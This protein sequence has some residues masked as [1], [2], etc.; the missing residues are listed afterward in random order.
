M[1]NA[2]GGSL[3]IGVLPGDADLLFDALL[4]EFHRVYPKISL[5]VIE[6]TKIMEQVIH[7]A[8]DIGV[9][10]TPIPDER[11]TVIPLLHEEFALAIRSDHSLAFVEVPLPSF[12]I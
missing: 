10:T 4:V 2:G 5:S 12:S 7:G 1:K 9:T 3:T 8:I 11:I 6:S